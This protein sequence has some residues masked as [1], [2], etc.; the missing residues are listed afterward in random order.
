M[1]LSLVPINQG[2]TT[3]QPT[4]KTLAKLNVRVNN[5]YCY[6]GKGVP[7]IPPGTVGSGA[8]TGVETGT[9][10]GAGTGVEMGTDVGTG[11]GVETGTGVGVE[12]V[13]GGSVDLG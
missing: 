9:G 11:M 8:G 12:I 2:N 7:S 6:G 13:T 4:Q 1:A 5:F 10:V 3:T